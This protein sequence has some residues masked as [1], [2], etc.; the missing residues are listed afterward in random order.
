MIIGIGE[1][2]KYQI[3]ELFS[4]LSL[5]NAAISLY[6]I[7]ASKQCADTS[8]IAASNTFSFNSHAGSSRY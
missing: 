6:S 4:V 3:V 7:V 5:A 1:Y 8:A 2:N